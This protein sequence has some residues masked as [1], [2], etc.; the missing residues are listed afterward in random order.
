M[1]PKLKI[2]MCSEASFL[3]SGFG[4]YTKELLTRLHNTEKYNIAEFASYGYVND[5][6]DKDIP[7]KYYANAV[8]ENDSRHREYSSRQD[9]QFGRWRFEKVLLDF[10]PDVVVDIR[11]GSQ[12]FGQ[13]FSQELSDENKLQL[14]IR[15]L[16]VINK[17]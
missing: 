12:T 1:K 5:H 16:A 8:R 3:S 7:W 17:K 14:F 10:K 2:L 4:T 11:K 15:N 9:N 6:R 13:H